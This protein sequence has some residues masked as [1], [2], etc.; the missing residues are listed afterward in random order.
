MS[1]YTDYKDK[2]KKYEDKFDNALNEYKNKYKKDATGFDLF[3]LQLRSLCDAV[4]GV[5]NSD[6]EEIDFNNIRLIVVGINPGKEEQK[7]NIY[8]SHNSDTGC[9]IRLFFLMNKNL[10]YRFNGDKN[11]NVIGLNLTPI[12]TSDEDGLKEIDDAKLRFSEDCMAKI[13]CELL[14]LESQKDIKIWFVNKNH[15]ENNKK[16]FQKRYGKIKKQILVFGH[17][18]KRGNFLV[19]I[20]KDYYE[21]KHKNDNKD[22]SLEDILNNIGE[23]N[24]DDLE[25]KKI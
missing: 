23:N 10:R 19:D 2:Y 7:D 21:N 1:E 11:D 18:G 17:P 22:F 4:D 24:R 20:Y 25:P 12:C 5:Y 3:K 15:W 16:N 8:F 14:V 13:I 9:Q 6:L